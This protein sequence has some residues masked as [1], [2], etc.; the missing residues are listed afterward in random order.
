MISVKCPCG[1]VN[2]PSQTRNCP[3]C[4]R[5]VREAGVYRLRRTQ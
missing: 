4:G 2:Y 1:R 3:N 5:P